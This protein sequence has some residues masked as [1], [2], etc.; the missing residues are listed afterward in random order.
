MMIADAPGTFSAVANF[1]MMLEDCMHKSKFVR[2]FPKASLPR[3]CLGSLPRPHT[4][5]T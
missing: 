2:G 1:V 4:R 3:A 5:N